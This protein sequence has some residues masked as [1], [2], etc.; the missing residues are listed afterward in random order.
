MSGSAREMSTL[1]HSAEFSRPVR[2]L[3]QLPKFVN[4]RGLLAYISSEIL[5]VLES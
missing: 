1:I 3:S 2:P 5:A 4:K